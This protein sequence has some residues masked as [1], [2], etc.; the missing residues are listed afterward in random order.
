[1][2]TTAPRFHSI[3]DRFDLTTLGAPRLECV[4]EAAHEL[5]FGPGKPIALV[6]FLAAAPRRTASRERLA[7]L[8]WGDRDPEDARRSLRQAL[9][10]IN[11][12]AGPSF[13]ESNA[14]GLTI[15][16]TLQSDVTALE[17]AV[18]AGDLDAAVDRYTGDFF[19]DF[20]SP[21][22]DEFERWASVERARLRGLFV[23]SAESLARRALDRGRFADAITL[24]HLVRVRAPHDET[25][26]QLLL[27]S[28]SAAGDVIG[29][30]AE[31]DHFDEW[32][33]TEERSPEPASVA[34]LRL[35]CNVR[36]PAGEHASG[37]EL[38]ADLVGRENEFSRLHD[39][40]LIARTGGPRSGSAGAGHSRVAL[41]LGDGGIG[42]SRL[43]ADLRTRIA[44]GRGQVLWCGVRAGDRQLAYATLASLAAGLAAMPGATGISQHSAAA[45]L[46]LD[47]ALSS[48]F[49]GTPDLSQ[50]DEALRRRG[51]A[52]L[53][54]VA[55]V[56]DDSPFAI[57]VDDLHWCDDDSLRAIAFVASHLS[58]QRVLLVLTSRTTRALPPLG[59][60]VTTIRLAPLVDEQVEQ[61]VTSIAPLPDEPWARAL[62]RLLRRCSAGVP[63][64][65]LE[66]LRLAMEQQVLRL[67]E[68]GW[69]CRSEEELDRTCQ[70]GAVVRRRIGVLSPAETSVLRTISAAEMP[71]GA[72]IIAAAT[73]LEVTH[74]TAAAV[75]L[76]RRGLVASAGSVW[77]V[78]HDEIGAAALALADAAELRAIQIGLGEARAAQAESAS[79]RRAV[80]H[81]VNAEAWDRAATVTREVLAAMP[82]CGPLDAELR[83]LLGAD[84]TAD[85]LAE[86]RGALPASIR[87]SRRQRVA[88]L[89]AG[90]I[91]ALW[92]GAFGVARL[93]AHS[94][95]EAELLVAWS[96]SDGLPRDVAR[97]ALT[98][99][100]WT[101]GRPLADAVREPR[102]TW[103]RTPFSESGAAVISPDGSQ[104]ASEAAFP[105]S[106]ELDVVLHDRT[107]AS[108]RLTSARGDDRPAA[109]SPDGTLLA[110]STARW[111]ANGHANLALIDVRTGELIRRLTQGD[112][113]SEFTARWSPD[114]SRLAFTRSI[115][116]GDSSVL[117]W[118]TMDA[119]REHCLSIAPWRPSDH[120]GFV[121]N[122]HLLVHVT[123]ATAQATL[124]VDL[125]TATFSR[126]AIPAAD[127]ATLDATGRWLLLSSLDSAGSA[128]LRIGPALALERARVFVAREIPGAHVNAWLESGPSDYITSMKVVHPPVPVALGAPHRLTVV[129]T[130]RTG[131]RTVPPVV[132]W[133]SLT[134]RIAAVDSD[135]VLMPRDTGRAIVEASAGGWRTAL[136]TI[137]VVRSAAVLVADEHWTNG[138]EA[139]WR[140]YGEPL[141]L[142]VDDARGGRAF[143]NNGDGEFYSG[144]YS[145]GEYDASRGLAIDAEFSAP[146]TRTQWQMISVGLRASAAFAPIARWDHRT[147]Y[148]PAP[149]TR[150][151]DCTFVY[152][153]G[154]GALARTRASGAE[155]LPNTLN[156]RP[157]ELWKGAWHVVRVQLMPD[158]RCGYAIDGAA[159]AI[160]ESGMEPPPSAHVMLQ[161]MSVGT[162]MLVG[163]VRVYTGVPPGVD[164][165][166]AKRRP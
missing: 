28:L 162:R 85:R 3:S 78:A 22:A 119:R 32:L 8:L 164:W 130:T 149:V 157:L 40:W 88:L 144:A 67:E 60:A 143:F 87:Y 25:G 90:V 77:R 39:L 92:L 158:G 14:D 54:L 131:K 64:L 11:R 161:G 45:L 129:A 113:A 105:D 31:A 159:V 101:E 10:M 46:A 102:G 153:I 66:A 124:N 156:G 33:R 53:E 38:A 35:A 135:G 123:N 51:L 125:A 16:S 55:A 52:M 80:R 24:A 112:A 86:I 72:E 7:D 145:I 84:V 97:A 34:A 17:V 151:L 133:R 160:H 109:F 146:I 108:R 165:T 20:A 137:P 127:R 126:T 114:G 41:I 49:S 120:I 61:L 75:E 110:I 59:D 73:G 48:F 89:A 96:G 30:R 19:A 15:T 98:L 1:M 103:R 122:S 166:G 107:G 93:G 36:A 56:A 83:S 65:V 27:E 142:I 111:N 139:R 21:G 138:V 37:T 91:V 76:E 132:L 47:P 128:T 154:E 2:A 115:A 148:P 58:D 74:A 141:P 29:A 12:A 95:P 155:P 94:G 44:A 50:G 117:C 4:G 81:F 134:P 163:R 9:W 79:R 69:K 152:P 99:E 6:A 18:R 140:F 63:L 100:G 62:P 150:Q 118:V 43:A 104:W 70:Q 42:K 116:G 13:I 106:G 23:H 147:G 5:L 121:D 57:V 71:I 68:D 26:W 82:R 136:D